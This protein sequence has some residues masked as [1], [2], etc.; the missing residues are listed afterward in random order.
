MEEKENDQ[1]AVPEDY[2]HSLAR[3]HGLGCAACGAGV[4]VRRYVC[5]T[6][7]RERTR[8]AT[9]R[10]TQE[11]KK[12]MGKIIKPEIKRCHAANK[13]T[14]FSHSARFSEQN[15]IFTNVSD[16]EHFSTGDG[17]ATNVKYHQGGWKSLGLGVSRISS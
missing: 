9:N 5:V 7:D 15:I 16:R 17:F 12:S 10:Q 6:H 2:F 11:E 3:A 14:V 1:I 13:N 8:K 4:C